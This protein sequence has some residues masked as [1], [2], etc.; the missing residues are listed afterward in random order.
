MTW[1]LRDK[2]RFTDTSEIPAGCILTVGKIYEVYDI[3]EGDCLVIESDV[4]H[5]FHIGEDEMTYVERID[6]GKE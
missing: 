3:Y 2:L 4:G 1:E 6:K 5:D